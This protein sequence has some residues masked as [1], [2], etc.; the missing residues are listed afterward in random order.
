MSGPARID[1]YLQ[2]YLQQWRGGQGEWGVR[3]RF[4]A[5]IRFADRI[6][7]LRKEC[8]QKH[9]EAGN[10][11]LDKFSTLVPFSFLFRSGVLSHSLQLMGLG[12]RGGW[13]WI[14]GAFSAA[15]MQG[16]PRSKI[17]ITAAVVAALASK[18]MACYVLGFVCG[19]ALAVL[20]RGLRNIH[21]VL[22]TKEYKEVA[23]A[24]QRTDF[25]IFL[26]G[27]ELSLSTILSQHKAYKA[28]Q[29]KKDIA[30][31]NQMVVYQPRYD[32]WYKQED[33]T[34]DGLKKLTHI[35]AME[36]AKKDFLAQQFIK[37]ATVVAI[38]CATIF[39]PAGGGMFWAASLIGL[40]TFG[41]GKVTYAIVRNNENERIK[42]MLEKNAEFRQFVKYQMNRRSLDL[43]FIKRNFK[44]LPPVYFKWRDSM[45]AIEGDI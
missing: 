4:D 15:V 19:S 16:I 9:D 33:F 22:R 11:P 10:L 13:P 3:H 27:K 21:N 29:Q 8:L 1:Y 7:V 44:L 18:K 38:L 43:D 12:A 32:M 42:K 39:F 23:E 35:Y 24:L 36:Q 25:Q 28:D 34:P 2:S 37:T 6:Q 26:Q 17:V 30:T 40:M 20:D 45:H 41:I 31:I 5:P 14:G